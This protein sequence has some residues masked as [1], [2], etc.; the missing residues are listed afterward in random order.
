MNPLSLSMNSYHLPSS[1]LALGIT[2]NEHPPGLILVPHV[3]TFSLILGVYTCLCVSFGTGLGAFK[4]D[5][6]IVLI[7]DLST[8]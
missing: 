2:Q 5:H 8:K 7:L 4:L 1:T 3:M 6:L